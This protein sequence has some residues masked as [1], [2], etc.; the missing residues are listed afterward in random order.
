[1]ADGRR[2]SFTVKKTRPAKV[3]VGTDDKGDPN[4]NDMEA[5]FGGLLDTVPK[6]ENHKEEDQKE[7]IKHTQ[8]ETE[9][10]KERR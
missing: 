5:A 4:E 7:E 9:E 10:D 6:D 2:K 3:A 8:E 1:M